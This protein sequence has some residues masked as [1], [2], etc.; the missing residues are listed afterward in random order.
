MRFLGLLLLIWFL[1]AAVILYVTIGQLEALGP[2]G[3]VEALLTV[4]R[5]Q[6][7]GTLVFFYSGLTA[8]VSLIAIFTGAGL[9]SEDLQARAL[10][11]YLV[12]PIRAF[13]YALGKSLV[14]PWV[15]FL[16]SAL[17]GLALWLL[18]GAWQMPGRSADFLASNMDVP[19]LVLRYVLVAGGAFTGLVLLLSASTSRRAVVSSLA[20]TVIFGGSMLAGIGANVK[21]TAGD[22]L[23]LLGLPVDAISGFLY[24][25]IDDKLAQ[26]A[27]RG[28]WVHHPG[29]EEFLP[30]PNAAAVLA[31]LLFVAGF[32]RV[33]LRARSVEVTE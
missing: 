4:S 9:V 26:L 28:L 5:T 15:L 10:T 17:P 20:A 12:R 6:L 23:R 16:F 1:I 32:L 13:D 29:P 33:W 18:V 25:A 27:R 19:L 14:V 22:V 30:D 3:T 31:A 21:G 2:L 24:A 11:L 7:L 8:L